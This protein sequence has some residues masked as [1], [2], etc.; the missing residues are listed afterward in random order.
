MDKRKKHYIGLFFL[1]CAFFCFANFFLIAVGKKHELYGLS[2][3][4]LIL[5]MLFLYIAVRLHVQNTMDIKRGSYVLTVNQLDAVCDGIMSVA[6]NAG[7]LKPSIE[8]LGD[9]YQTQ[10]WYS[11][12][13]KDKLFESRCLEIIYQPQ[14]QED[15]LKTAED[16][17]DLKLMENLG[18]DKQMGY[19]DSIVWQDSVGYI[20]MY[21]RFICVDV[22]PERFAEII[23]EDLQTCG[24]NYQSVA[25][26]ALDTQ[27]MYM[28]AWNNG[29]LKRYSSLAPEKEMKKLCQKIILM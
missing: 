19:R 12:R 5:Y 27:R 21:T 26:I 13:K 29:S 9:L 2:I 23:E 6:M 25:G 22:E 24:N 20:F 15:A 7:Y 11:T 3:L 17:L 10:M 14:F 16:Y 8:L 28:A 18:Y 4:L 1:V